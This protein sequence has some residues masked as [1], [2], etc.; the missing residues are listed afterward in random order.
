MRKMNILAPDLF[1]EK[2]MEG[3]YEKLN[4]THRIEIL[5][6]ESENVNI[7]I[8]TMLVSTENS[9]YALPLMQEYI[10]Y[11][12]IYEGNIERFCIDTC[13]KIREYDEFVNGT[14]EI[15]VETK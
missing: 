3:V 11:I 1:V 13:R 4:G 5:N 2:L 9:C 6:F 15:E 10:N 12:N 8:P 7:Q 14:D